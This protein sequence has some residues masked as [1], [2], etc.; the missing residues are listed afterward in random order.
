MAGYTFANGI[1]TDGMSIPTWTED[2]AVEQYLERTGFGALNSV[3]G[4]ELGASIELHEHKSD[5]SYFAFVSPVGNNIQEVY[6][7]NFPSL[8]LFVRDYATGFSAMALNS[9]QNQLLEIAEKLNPG[10]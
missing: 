6:I 1:W 3:I 10:P 2:E 5:G 8:M 9:S 7:P 4:T